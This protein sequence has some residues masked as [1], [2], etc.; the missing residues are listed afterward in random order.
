MSRRRR[1]NSPSG[2]RTV[3]DYYYKFRCGASTYGS[4]GPLCKPNSVDPS[5]SYRFYASCAFEFA[6]ASCPLGWGSYTD[7]LNYRSGCY[8]GEHYPNAVAPYVGP[9]QYIGSPVLT[10]VII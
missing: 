8:E 3:T 5:I 10:T 7:Y 9:S 1:I 4:S 2:D 6:G